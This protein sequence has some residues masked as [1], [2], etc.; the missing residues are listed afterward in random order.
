MIRSK[1]TRE[2]LAVLMVSRG[3]FKGAEA[4]LDGNGEDYA[5]VCKI[6]GDIKYLRGE[7]DEAE[8]LYRR[9]LQVNSEY[10]EAAVSLALT[11][12]RKGRGEEAGEIL[13]R[14]LEIEPENVL[15]RNLV[16]RGPLDL[17]Q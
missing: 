6:M 1:R 15:A 5:D 11:L 4:I 13:E 9:S 8:D 16:G 12:R 17:E 7:L 3:D 2:K 14:I 10:S